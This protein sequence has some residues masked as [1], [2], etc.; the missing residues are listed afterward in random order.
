MGDQ[1]KRTASRA[2]IAGWTMD[3]GQIDGEDDLV[4]ELRVV[5]PP[6]SAGR[7]KAGI[8]ARN[9]KTHGQHGDGISDRANPAAEPVNGA[10]RDEEQRD[11]KRRK[12]KTLEEPGDAGIGALRF[13]LGRLCL[14]CFGHVAGLRSGAA[15]VCGQA[16]HT[17]GSGF[18][19]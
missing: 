4:E 15:R 17:P 8:D 13:F 1:R 5:T 11:P 10:G 3:E 12:A 2:A 9:D 18:C 19:R 14:Q 7:D 16:I 6:F